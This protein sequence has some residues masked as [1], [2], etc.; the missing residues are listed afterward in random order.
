MKD[1]LLGVEIGNGDS[2]SVGWYQI[3][4]LLFDIFS[5]HLI[6]WT[7]CLGFIIQN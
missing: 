7:I 3:V 2:Y 4:R 5:G 1:D 6:T